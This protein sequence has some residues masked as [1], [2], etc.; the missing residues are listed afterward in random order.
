MILQ[1]FL[2]CLL[3]CSRKAYSLHL[4]KREIIRSLYT[5]HRCCKEFDADSDAASNIF[6]EHAY[7]DSGNNSDVNTELNSKSVK[8]TIS[9]RIESLK[10][11]QE[12]ETYRD[13]SKVYLDEKSNTEKIVYSWNNV[14]M[15]KE[16]IVSYVQGVFSPTLFHFS[17]E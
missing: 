16:A 11:N 3:L 15:E 2:A 1:F 8:S 9:D 4:H 6:D 5:I 14:D 7:I 17:V 10:F 13:E 12:I